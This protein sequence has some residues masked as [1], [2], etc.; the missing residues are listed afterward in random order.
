MLHLSASLNLMASHTPAI[1]VLNLASV[2]TGF[3]E[4]Q[5]TCG[6]PYGENL[7]SEEGFSFICRRCYNTR[8]NMHL[9]LFT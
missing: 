9:I 2:R 8:V 3:V 6:M 7:N 5:R 4:E 1:R